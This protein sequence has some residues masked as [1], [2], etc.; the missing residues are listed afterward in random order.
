MID[1]SQFTGSETFYRHSLNKSIIY[2]DGV[3]HIAEEAKAYWLIDS[4]MTALL[5]TGLH[6]EDFV[7]WKLVSKGSGAVLTA[8]D[9]NNNL[10]Y[11]QRIPYTDFPFGEFEEKEIRIWYE[12]NTLYLPSER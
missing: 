3:S 10:L 12:N 8:D 1:L 7:G 4:I 6:K 5:Y 9:G 2:T 11:T